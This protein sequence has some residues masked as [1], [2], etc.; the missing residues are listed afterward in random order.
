MKYQCLTKVKFSNFN[1]ICFEKASTVIILV[2][3]LCLNKQH[4]FNY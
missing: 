3:A 4:G 1:L 2:A